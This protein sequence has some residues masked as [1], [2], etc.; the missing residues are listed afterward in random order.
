ML[1]I[2]PPFGNYIRLPNTI[3]IN[4][5]FTY[6]ERCGLFSQIMRTLR[7]SIKHNGWVNNIGLK[8]K[9]ID[10]AIDNYQK[11][12]ITSIAIMQEKEIPAIL[13]RIPDDM[14]IELNVSCPNIRQG[15]VSNGIQAFHNSKREWC[16]IKLS[17]L[18]TASEIDEYYQKGFRQFHCSNTLPIG[19]KGGLSG[20]ALIPYTSEMVRKIKNSYPDT[21]VIAGGGIRDIHTVNLYK[22]MGADHVSVSTLCMNP[23]SFG[24]LYYQLYKDTMKS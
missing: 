14:N 1:F 3:P 21:T 19:D 22:T 10:Y 23:I 9:G 11:D 13:Q 7:F 16:I 24:L 20:P 18:T 5:S 8:N 17:P 6:E 2:S 4:G 12:E 15:V